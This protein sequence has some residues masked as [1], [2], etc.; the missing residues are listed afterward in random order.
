MHRLAVL[1]LPPSDSHWPTF[2]LWLI[3]WGAS[4]GSIG[5]HFDS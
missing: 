5:V 4:W 2:L 3:I 1:S